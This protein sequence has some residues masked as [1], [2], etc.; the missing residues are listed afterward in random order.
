[1]GIGYELKGGGWLQTMEHL[2]TLD[3]D[4][5]SIADR[6]AFIA[7]WDYGHWAVG[8][9]RHPTV[10]DPFQNHYEV[11]GR[12][13]AAE[14][15]QEVVSYLNL[16]L[17]NTDWRKNGGRFSPDVQAVVAQYPGLERVGS[18]SG[19][20]RELP[21]V[22]QSVQGDAV[23]TLYDQLQAATGNRMHYVG[24]DDRMWP[25]S[26]S[27]PGIFYAP[28]FL[29]NKL[30]EDFVRT[31]LQTTTGLTFEQRQYAL[32]ERGN[33]YR[34]SNAEYVETNS[35]R[36]YEFV[37]GR[38]YPQGRTP[39]QG[40]SED[41]GLPLAAQPQIERTERFSR[42]FYARAFGGELTYPSM[43]TTGVP[44]GTPP[45][46]GLLHFRAIQE[47]ATRLGERGQQF[48]LQANASVRHTVLLEYY[49]GVEVSGRV[50]D[51]A[52]AAMSGL[53]VTFVD[54]FGARHH[55]ATT[56]ANGTYTVVA[57]F[58]VDGDLRLEVRDGTDV[59][60]SDT[61]L[62]FSR[63]DA[64]GLGPQAGPTITIP[65]GTLSGIAYR[66]LDGVAGFNATADQLLED[67]RITAEGRTATTGEDGRFSLGTFQAGR[68]SLNATLA[69]YDTATQTA[70][71]RAGEQVEVQVALRP[72][73]AP[74]EIE[75]TADNE[76]VARATIEVQGTRT[77]RATTNSTGVA[78][79]R[80]EPGTYTLRLNHTAEGADGR[81]YVYTGTQQLTV[82][83]GGEPVRVQMQ[84][85][86]REA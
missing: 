77:T 23:F 51:D 78:T 75:V 74:V 82:E 26:Y 28:V 57:P 15:E 13:L 49:R 48:G 14:S 61:S 7:W 73:L 53:Q 56:D 60:A 1:F 58:S 35:G 10:A 36:V 62:Q 55:A 25:R 3:A 85:M 29:A 16:L 47:S 31:T 34:L 65:R 27:D 72:T 42:T 63:D 79:V 40:A 22:R 21:I 46:D 8:I 83:F 5:G 64:R 81:E 41:S 52:G 9:G 67:V 33:S 69:G 17:L 80:L 45:G 24:V 12:I 38:L 59:L 66:D 32:D 30:P 44:R 70:V 20:D 71:V 2:A 39:L 19:Y 84:V 4:T 68:V 37:N 11:A 76:T 43:S 54:G 6:P 86:R 50:L 18:V